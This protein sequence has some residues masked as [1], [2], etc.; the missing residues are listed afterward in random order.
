[1][2]GFISFLSGRF[3]IAMTFGLVSLLFAWDAVSA[4]T[5]YVLSPR[6]KETY[7]LL[8]TNPAVGKG[9]DF[10]KV[11]VLDKYG[12]TGVQALMDRM[13]FGVLKRIAIFP[14]GVSKLADQFGNIMPD[15]FLLKEGSTALDFANTIHTDLGQGF[16]RAI[17]VKTRKTLGKEHVLS[18]RDVIEIISSK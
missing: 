8:S 10:I 4:E 3:I 6:V 9:L 13:V 14:G 5:S 15:C 2:K 12:G 17:D 16:I 18:N 11:N 7:N 1:M